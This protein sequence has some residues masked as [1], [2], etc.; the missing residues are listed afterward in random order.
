MKVLLMLLPLLCAVPVLAASRPRPIETQL[1]TPTGTLFGTL[2]L[3]EGAAPYPVALLIA[4]SGPTDR[5]GN[6]A[7]LAGHN[8]SLKMLAEALAARGIAS[9]RYDKRGIG[10][11]AKAATDESAL[12]F[13]TYIADAVLWAKQL[14][15]DARF[16]RLTIIGHSEGALIGAVAAREVGARAFVSLAGVGRPAPDVLLG[17]LRASLPPD[18][19]QRAEEIIRD[20]RAGTT[21]ETVPAELQVL[22]RPSVQP[23]LISWF[24][25]DPAT[26]IK[27][28]EM[29]V[30]IAQGTTDIQVSVEDAK[31]PSPPA[32][33]PAWGEG[34]AGQTLI[35]QR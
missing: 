29:P 31:R 19:M 16:S 25:Y 1:E 7:L 14:Q 33:L 2:E 30:L 34:S 21:V 17:Q 12:R 6:S 8:N 26:E 3:P 35:K 24:R 15:G 10:D 20:L 23:Y 27:K 11:S 28:L 13:E 22:F 4:G 5:N 9:L 18:L 32:P